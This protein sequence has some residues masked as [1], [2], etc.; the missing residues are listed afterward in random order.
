MGRWGRSDRGAG[1]RKATGVSPLSA[2]RS[3]DLPHG[4]GEDVMDAGGGRGIV[5]QAR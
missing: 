3:H 4:K 2:V 1:N 5:K